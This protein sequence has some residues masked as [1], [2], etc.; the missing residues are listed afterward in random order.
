MKFKFSFSQY[1]QHL[2]LGGK[3]R[4][5]KLLSRKKQCLFRPKRHLLL[6]LS[7]LQD[8]AHTQSSTGPKSPYSGHPV[9]HHIEHINVHGH[10]IHNIYHA[11]LNSKKIFI[12]FLK[13]FYFQVYFSYFVT[14][15]FYFQ[16]LTF[17]WLFK[18]FPPLVSSELISPQSIPCTTFFCKF[19][20]S[21]ESGH[22]VTPQ[23]VMTSLATSQASYIS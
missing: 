20:G 12:I 9:T 6:A 2:L 21:S 1:C 18:H 8:Q 17:P 19:T 14:Y 4:N 16:I 11:C 5:D 7:I 23:S 10:L 3:T 22:T 13:L 15:N